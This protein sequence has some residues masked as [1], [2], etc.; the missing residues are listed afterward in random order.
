LYSG[1]GD[2]VVQEPGQYGNA[3]VVA[4][5]AASTDGANTIGI[6]SATGNIITDAYF[7][8]D[9]GYLSNVASSYGNANVSAYLASGTNTANIITTGNVSGTYVLGNGSQLTGL[10]ATYGNANVTTLLANLGSN[11]ISTTG[12]VTAGYF[13]GNG[14]QLTGIASS[15]GNANVSA[16]LASGTNTADMIT[17]ANIIGGNLKTSGASG[18]IV[19]A[20]YVSANF[21]LGD[22][23]LL[24]NITSSYGNANVSA[25]LSS[26]NITANI[27]TTGNISAT[28]N[29][30][31]NYILGNGSQLTGLPATYGNTN[32][33]SLLAS[34]G[35][36]SISTT[37]NVTA[38]YFTGNGSLLTNITGANVTGVVANAT[39]AAT[40]GSA[41]S[42][43][44]AVTVTGNAQANITS[45]GTLTGLSVSGNTTSGNILTAGIV[46]AAGNVTGNYFIGNGSQL[47]GI[48]TSAGGSNT[49]IQYN[50]GTV[51]AG[52]A[53][54][55]FS[56]V[57]GNIGLGNLIIGSN[58][59]G[60]AN[61]GGTAQRI[62]TIA[63]DNGTLST[64]TALGNGQIV[65]G[66]GVNGNLSLA[67]TGG[68]GMNGMR[69]AKF[70]VWDSA[71]LAESGAAAVRWSGVSSAGI[72][73]L[74]GNIAL[75]STIRAGL[76]GVSV[77]GGASANTW[78][79]TNGITGI[80]GQN[81][82]V[83]V[84]SGNPSGLN[85]NTTVN[86]AIGGQ[87]QINVFAGSSLGNAAGIFAEITG[88][89]NITNS[90][91]CFVALSGGITT[92]FTPTRAYG[93][94]MPS[95]VASPFAGTTNNNSY[96]AATDYYFLRND[97]A[98]AQTQLGTL[99]SYNEYNAVSATTSGALTIDKAV[100]QVHQVNLTGNITSVTY[101]NMVSS[102]SDSV[103]TDEEVD[104]V[105]IIFNQGATGGYSVALP[106]G[107]TYKYAGG[108]NTVTTTANSVT[109]VAVTVARISG[110]ATYLTT[111]SPGFV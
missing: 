28:G 8:G 87:S 99:R 102:L 72:V 57:T 14:S 24:S 4:L 35:S 10:P 19:G 52:N 41:G 71:N 85:G 38:S 59:T 90:A 96:R 21:Y 76:S 9:G 56:N 78:N 93:V 13:I 44:T 54:M 105:T 103:N 40:A 107:A 82:F 51:F 69:G 49:Q 32:V 27:L 80:S 61:T 55:T 45:V 6:V 26:G 30:T 29:V 37:G 22:G 104:T 63:P 111:V 84:G 3:N 75:N 17:T 68:L 108:V 34:F 31:G 65:I 77:G 20:D 81:S 53:A 48:T 109:L 110:T 94:Y 70:V 12:N 46:S 18:N 62:N 92:G 98:V 58:A 36:N 74:T 11:A 100:S 73:T 95:N 101:A 43:T 60:N 97:D 25:Y 91:A 2:I 7:I 50:N 16:Y 66:N 47:T 79:S 64:A 5:L 89:G 106:A 39:Y 88:S 15:Y 42:A 1:S 83:N 86:N 33:V 67:Q 23:G